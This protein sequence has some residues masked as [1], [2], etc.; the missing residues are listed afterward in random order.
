MLI[1]LLFFSGRLIHRIPASLP[2]CLCTSVH[3]PTVMI[4]ILSH[5]RHPFPVTFICRWK[6]S[7][8]RSIPSARGDPPLCFH[9]PNVLYQ[10][11]A[12]FQRLSFPHGRDDRIWTCDPFVPNEVHYQAV[13]H[14]DASTILPLYRRNARKKW[15]NFIIS[16]K[17]WSEKFISTL[18]GTK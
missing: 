12:L 2:P 7:V 14:P 9:G 6:R 8:C 18:K 15:K 16:G 10:K 5:A 13:L 4:A 3:D 11:K 1:F 17:D